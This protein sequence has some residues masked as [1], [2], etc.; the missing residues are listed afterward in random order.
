MG[1]G[2]I[3]RRQGVMLVIWSGFAQFKSQQEAQFKQEQADEREG[4]RQSKYDSKMAAI[5][6]ER[7]IAS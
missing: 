3:G 1:I 7:E 6:L 5:Q 2:G 4:F